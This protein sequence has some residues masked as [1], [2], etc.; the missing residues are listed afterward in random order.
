[1]IKRIYQFGL[2]G[3]AYYFYDYNTKLIR[4]CRETDK[5]EKALLL[6][7]LDS[8]AFDFCLLYYESERSGLGASLD[9]HEPQGEQFLREWVTARSGVTETVHTIA[10]PR[11]SDT[12]LRLSVLG[13][14]VLE[15]SS[16]RME[17]LLEKSDVSFVWCNP[18]SPLQ[19]HPEEAQRIVETARSDRRYRTIMISPEVMMGATGP[20][21][22][23]GTLS[24]MNAE[25]LAGVCL[26][27][28]AKPGT[29]VIYGC[30]CAPMDL[31]NAEISQGNFET[32]LINAASVQLA[33]RYGLPSRIAPGNTSAKAPGP[34][35]AAETAV[36]LLIGAAAGGNIIT[37]GLLDSTLMISYE[38][39]ALVDELVRQTQS[40][41]P[42]V[43][44]DSESLGLEVIQRAG[45][46]SPD[47]I[48]DEHTLRNMSRDIYYSDFTGR[49]R[50]S[51]E[52]WYEKAH[53]RVLAI[54]AARNPN[55]ENP[56][57]V[58]E[59]LS[60]VLSRI[61]ENRTHLTSP[62]MDWWRFYVQDII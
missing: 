49:I 58:E 57:E 60:A 32:A 36:G 13:N 2:V 41:A 16:Q 21:T 22:L 1:M 11:Y 56:P 9:V 30:V 59:R 52:P 62:A 42:G 39:L 47:Y 3:N 20:V 26:S 37:T 6:E 43:R 27:Q 35:A 18:I 12:E 33:D 14:M 38:H 50:K 45:H 24:Q 51:Y 53:E 61:A 5:P 31:R 29:Q 17:G 7:H 28:I 23:A 40:I 8:L 46:P 34:R 55:L 25:I 44:T 19:Y 10:H 15:G 54:L 4:D 48:Q